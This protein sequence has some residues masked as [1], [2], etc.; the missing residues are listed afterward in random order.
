MGLFG[1][2]RTFLFS[3]LTFNAARHPF[4]S[5]VIQ[6][7]DLNRSPCRSTFAPCCCY[8]C[9]LAA[10]KCARENN[11][12]SLRP[13]DSVYGAKNTIPSRKRI[14]KNNMTILCVCLYKFGKRSSYPS[15]TRN[16]R[17]LQFLKFVFFP[18][19]IHWVSDRPRLLRFVKNN[20]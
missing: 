11:L 14:K 4:R 3:Q 6:F 13:R 12:F 2:R 1:S 19:H 8:C 17:N 10:G 18:P 16:E 5:D 20:I 9:S 7:P 15:L